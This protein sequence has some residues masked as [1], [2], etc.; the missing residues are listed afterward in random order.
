M[1]YGTKRKTTERKDKKENT[2]NYGLPLKENLRMTETLNMLYKR[3]LQ[4]I[5]L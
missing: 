5:F 4:L 2:E 1:D 3:R